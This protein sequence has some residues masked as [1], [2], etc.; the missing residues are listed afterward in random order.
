M[1]VVN[2]AFAVLAI[3]SCAEDAPRRPPAPHLEGRWPQAGPFL[4]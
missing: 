3:T 2:A 1:N 4:A